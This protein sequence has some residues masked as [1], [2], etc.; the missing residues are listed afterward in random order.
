MCTLFMEIAEFADEPYDSLLVKVEVSQVGSQWYIKKQT[1]YYQ[2]EVRTHS[3]HLSL[4]YELLPQETMNLLCPPLSYP[5]VFV[6]QLIS[7][8]CRWNA[9]VF[10]TLGFWS[11]KPAQNAPQKAK[12]NGSPDE[13]QPLM[14][15]GNGST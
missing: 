13:R 15:N 2:P 3:K 8:T 4:A 11:V 14:A 1:D 9:T 10:Q 6:K 7:M 12:A 5:I